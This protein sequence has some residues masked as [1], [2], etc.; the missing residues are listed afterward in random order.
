MDADIDFISFEIIQNATN[1]TDENTNNDQP[2]PDS[3]D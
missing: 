2:I 1:S 3:F